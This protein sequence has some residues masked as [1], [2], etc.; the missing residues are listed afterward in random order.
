MMVD[1]DKLHS[2]WYILIQPIVQNKNLTHSPCTSLWCHCLI[3]SSLIC[4]PSL[5]S[6]ALS[7]LLASSQESV[8]SSVS[9][10]LTSFWY[11]LISS[12]LIYF[13]SSVSHSL[14]G[15]LLSGGLS[16]LVIF[17]QFFLLSHLLSLSFDIL[18]FFVA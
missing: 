1:L 3:S 17:S 6:G 15:F 10:P 4:L 5:L 9:L 12:S 16:S 7:F 14:A 2:M 18:C 13:L 8:L 11:S